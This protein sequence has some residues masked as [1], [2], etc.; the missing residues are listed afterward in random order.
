[1]RSV[2]HSGGGKKDVSIAIFLSLLFHGVVLLVLFHPTGGIR[3][4]TGTIT[5]AERLSHVEE[6]IFKDLQGLV[7]RYHSQA[8]QLAAS[9]QDEEKEAWTLEKMPDRLAKAVKA[10]GVQVSKVQI[11]PSRNA[12]AETGSPQET[13]P[14]ERHTIAVRLESEGRHVFNDILA[15]SHAVGYSTLNSDFFT[16]N[17]EVTVSETEGTETVQFIVPT[18]DCRL[19]YRN[20]LSPQEFLM[21][22]SVRR[23]VSG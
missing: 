2:E 9:L 4:S 12:Q 19:L 16:D 23:G 1:M 10:A 8:I 3:G 11:W 14:Q 18:M 20:K 17:L 5:A 7:N 22:A 21:G 13:P 15:I 6:Y